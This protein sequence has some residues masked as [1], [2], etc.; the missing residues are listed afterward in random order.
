MAM[1]VLVGE[2]L[3]GCEIGNRLIEPTAES[4]AVLRDESG[5]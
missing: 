4:L 1:M 3:P 5:D 2:V